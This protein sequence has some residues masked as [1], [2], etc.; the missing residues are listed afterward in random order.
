MKKFIF[1][2][3][4]S[5]LIGSTALAE[6]SNPCNSN[7]TY[8]GGFT[9]NLYDENLAWVYGNESCTVEH[10]SP[11][12]GQINVSNIAGTI[13]QYYTPPASFKI[14]LDSDLNTLIKFSSSDIYK[15]PVVSLTCSPL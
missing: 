8:T 15:Y 5:S 14:P 10:V 13:I 6:P 4:L 2:G 7:A 9:C 12:A 11:G 3:I 1:I